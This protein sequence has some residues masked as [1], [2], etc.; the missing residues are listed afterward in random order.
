MFHTRW[1]CSSSMSVGLGNG[2]PWSWLF[3][4]PGEAGVQFRCRLFRLDRA[5]IIGALA[6]FSGLCCVR[7]LSQLP[8]G[9]GRFIPCRIG[10]SHCKLRADLCFQPVLDAMFAALLPATS[11][12]LGRRSSRVKSLGKDGKRNDA[13]PGK[14]FAQALCSI[15]VETNVALES[16]G[17]VERQ[18]CF[19]I[20]AINDDVKSAVVCKS[21]ECKFEAAAAPGTR[22]CSWS[23]FAET[24]E[25][26]QPGG[27]QIGLPVIFP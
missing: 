27:R 16:A 2:L 1:N 12:I 18:E 22:G 7:A 4:E 23:G 8:G 5:S 24:Q 19:N 14:V 11:F 6:D 13:Q 21:P 15:W 20:D 17:L 9:I 10:A 3:R 25:E 26:V